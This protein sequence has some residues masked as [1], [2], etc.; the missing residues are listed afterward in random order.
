[1]SKVSAVIRD[2][3]ADPSGISLIK[4]KQG[5][6]PT[7]C[8]RGTM[9]DLPF[10]T[11]DQAETMIE[12]C[13][14]GTRTSIRSFSV[15]I[16]TGASMQIV[17]IPCDNGIT[18]IYMHMYV[19]VHVLLVVTCISCYIGRGLLCRKESRKEANGISAGSPYQRFM[20]YDVAWTYLE[21]ISV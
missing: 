17:T 5:R 15:A 6:K 19:Y 12:G 9:T 11:P 2:L 4:Y 20:W 14:E 7:R 1:M 3:L 18:W 13:V 21:A 10:F 16:I 8:S